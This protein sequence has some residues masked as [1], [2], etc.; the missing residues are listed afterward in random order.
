MT[1]RPIVYRLSNGQR[2]E[3]LVRGRQLRIALPVPP[4]EPPIPLA[5]A[6]SVLTADIASLAIEAR[7]GWLWVQMLRPREPKG[8]GGHLGVIVDDPLGTLC[9]CVRVVL[10]TL[11]PDHCRHTKH[12]IQWPGS[13]VFLGAVYPEEVDNI[14]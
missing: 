2:K 7:V 14:E 12:A 4:V 11:R 3:L 5:W 9:Q 13:V 6:R 8:L 10:V 1:E